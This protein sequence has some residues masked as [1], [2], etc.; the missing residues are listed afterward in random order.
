MSNY[1]QKPGTGVLFKN[2]KKTSPNQPDWSGS[3]ANELG[4]PIRVAGWTKVGKNG[5]KFISWVMSEMKETATSEEPQ[6]GDD[7]PF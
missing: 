6:R 2:D 1:T 3:G 7:L 5:V 4:K